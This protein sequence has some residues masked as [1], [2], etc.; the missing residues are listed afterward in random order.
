VE[1]VEP[2][3]IVSAS[4]GNRGI[5]VRFRESAGRVFLCAFG[6]S[7]EFVISVVCFRKG[8]AGTGERRGGRETRDKKT[9]EEGGGYFESDRASPSHRADIL[10]VIRIPKVAWG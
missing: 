2:A 4:T 9:G 3:G 5:K 8:L 1:V 6:S 10:G 7:K